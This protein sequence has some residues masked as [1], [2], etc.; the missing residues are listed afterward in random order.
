MLAYCKMCQ[1]TIN[2][3]FIM[4]YSTGPVVDRKIKNIVYIGK[5]CLTG[6][7]VGNR[8]GRRVNKDLTNDV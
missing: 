1:F 2:Y 5:G 3:G 4:L 7:I 8:V 6:I